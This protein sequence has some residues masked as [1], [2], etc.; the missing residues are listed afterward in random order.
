MNNLVPQILI[1]GSCCWFVKD[2]KLKFIAWNL[3]K[4]KGFVFG[5]LLCLLWLWQ[6]G[7]RCYF[8]LLL[9]MHAVKICQAFFGGSRIISLS[10]SLSFMIFFCVLCYVEE[11]QKD[12]SRVSFVPI[13][14]FLAGVE[15]INW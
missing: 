7:N 13:T 9:G 4:V 14:M 12:N 8:I 11:I 3:D 5:R 15:C 6:T 10:L 1:P 2:S